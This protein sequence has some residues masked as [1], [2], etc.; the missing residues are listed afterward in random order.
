MSDLYHYD[1]FND[2]Y[3]SYRGTKEAMDAMCDLYGVGYVDGTLYG[4]VEEA[5]ASLTGYNPEKAKSLMAQACTEL[6][7]AGLYTKGEEITIRVAYS[8]G[9]LTASDE[10]QITKINEFL[11]AAAADSGFGTITLVGVGNVANRYET[12]GKGNFAIGYGAWGGAA[13]HPFRYMRLYCDPSQ[14]TIHE[15]ACWNPAEETLTLSVG[16]K[17]VTKTWQEWS[18]SLVGNG[19]YANASAGI[20]LEIT[21]EMEEKFLAKFYRIPLAN[22]C[23]ATVLSHQVSYYTEDYNVMYGFGGME[24]MRYDYTDAK[25]T[26][27]VASAGGQLFYN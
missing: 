23:A 19:E 1:I 27:Y 9:E 15:S 3:S 12:V 13:F 10:A 6:V 20:K 18:R 2:P 8:A 11:N 17:Y 25:W 5:Y 24:L 21:A 7:Q 14:Q 4:T 26:E 16:G 22:A